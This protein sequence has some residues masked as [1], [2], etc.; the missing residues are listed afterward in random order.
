MNTSIEQRF[1]GWQRSHY[2]DVSV[3][4]L[5]WAADNLGVIDEVLR[6][7]KTFRERYNFSTEQWD[8]PSE[9]PE[10][11]LTSKMLEFCKGKT[12]KDHLLILYYAGHSGGGPEECIWSATQSTADSPWLG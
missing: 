2:T 10:H 5:R 3:L 12:K 9:E 1:A 6:L 11:E 4:L 7:E 8:I